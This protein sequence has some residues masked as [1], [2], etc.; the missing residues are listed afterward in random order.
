MAS[1]IIG[2]DED[3]FHAPNDCG[4]SEHR[5]LLRPAPTQPPINDCAH[6][7]AAHEAVAPANVAPLD[8]LRPHPLLRSFPLDAQHT[9]AVVPS[10]SRVAVLDRA[11]MALVGRLPLG[12]ATVTAQER[13]AIVALAAAG[14]L[15][16]EQHPALNPPLPPTTLVG[17][18]HLTNA[19]NLRC[20]YCYLHKTS[21][22]MSAETGRAAIDTLVRTALLHGY[23]ALT[24]KY[25]GGEPTLKL[26]L[27]AEL[28]RYAQAQAAAV[29]LSLEGG[30]L[31]NGTLIT[32]PVT[33][34]LRELGL[35]L[36]ISLDGPA[37]SHNA[38]RPTAGGRPSFARAQ[39]GL[40]AA[41]EAGLRPTVGITVTARSIASL[42]EL[43]TWLL[44]QELAFG[45]SLYRENAYSASFAE[46]Q[47]DERSIIDGLRAAYA[48]IARRPPPWS[49]L[50][51][52]LDRTNLSGGHSHSCSAGHNYLV[53]DHDGRIA[54]CQMTLD[55]PVTDIGVRDPLSLI[56][57]D[58]H[59]VQNL[60]V[61]E[62]EG[63]R[64]CDWRYWCGGGCSVATFRAT[65]RYD[66][67]SPNCNI[68][69]VLYPEVVR[70]EGLRL[71]R[72][73]GA[74]GTHSNAAIA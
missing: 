56:R 45:I 46:L 27:L 64:S 15:S 55:Q 57:S 69:Q 53:I 42:P 51:S 52:L 61:D 58:P 35:R 23:P 71:L 59:G 67:R 2:P 39:A 8:A 14:L 21:A 32:A 16:A 30:V 22:S 54:T 1:V 48:V 12:T 43:I 29:G 38:Q 37:E 24:L 28:H 65:G 7:A 4:C 49:A 36:M 17:W 31:S 18:L 50:S 10:T 20:T 44:D 68:Y 41:I 33:A 74:P 62:K 72:W 34:T 40:L 63:C 47:L 6:G 13:R 19:C 3:P 60:S 25:A 73:Y 70:L 26:A 66:V 9:V 11:A 5:P